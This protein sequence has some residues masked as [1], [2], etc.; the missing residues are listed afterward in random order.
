MYGVNRVSCFYGAFKEVE[1]ERLTHRRREKKKEMDGER[2]VDRE[3]K[4][5][6]RQRENEREDSVLTSLNERKLSVS[7]RSK[8]N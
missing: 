3:R 4:R 6:G 7:T 2:E 8:I 5:E 1:K